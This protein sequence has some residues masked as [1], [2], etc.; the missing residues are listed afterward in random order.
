MMPRYRIERTELHTRVWLID[1]PDEDAAL[2]AYPEEEDIEEY[3]YHSGEPLVT[4]EAADEEPGGA[5]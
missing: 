3:G 4:I 5:R 2:E 1:A